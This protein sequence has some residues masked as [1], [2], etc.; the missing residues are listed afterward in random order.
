VRDVVVGQRRPV[1]ETLTG[2]PAR[3]QAHVIS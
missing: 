3:E 1:S 2:S